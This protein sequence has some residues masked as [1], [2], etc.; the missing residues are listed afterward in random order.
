[1]RFAIG[2]ALALGRTV[3]R[4]LLLPPIVAYFLATSAVSRRASR[5]FLRRALPRAPTLGDVARHFYSFAGCT[6]DRAFFLSGRLQKFSIVAHRPPEVSAVAARH[7]GC[8]LMVAHFGSSDALRV[9]GVDRHK[10]NLSILMDRKHGQM[11]TQ[12]FERLNPALAIDVIDAAQRGPQLVLSLKSALDRGRM[13][14]VMADRARVDEAKIA[15]EFMGATARLPVG[16]WVLAGALGVPVI[17]GFGIH[18][19][20]NRYESHFELMTDCVELP[21]GERQKAIEGW[22]QRYAGRLEHYARLAPYNWFNFFDF[23]ADEPDSH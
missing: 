9:L 16:P 4:W 13:V 21:R 18:V 12:L 23:W 11:I 3:G 22:A 6:L 20:G 2:L 7:R 17:L 5:R 1:M 8:L 19:G 14:G 15:V 10:L